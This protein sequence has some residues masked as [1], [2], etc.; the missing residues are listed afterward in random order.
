MEELNIDVTEND[1]KNNKQYLI[2]EGSR[3]YSAA[4]NIQYLPKSKIGF[5]L[6]CIKLNIRRSY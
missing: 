4:R 2:I 6:Q 1:N 3:K 5:M